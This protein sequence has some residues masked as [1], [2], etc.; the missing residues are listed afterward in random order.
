MLFR[1]LRIPNVAWYH[2]YKISKVKQFLTTEQLKTV[3]HAY[4]ISRLDQNNSLLLGLPKFMIK[5]LQMIQ[6]AAARLLLG[7]R[8]RDHVTPLLIQLHW[9]PVEKRI[10]FKVLLL[11][12]KSLHDI[13]PAYL[14]ELLVPY[15]PSS[16]VSLRSANKELLVL[17]NRHYVE[18]KKRDFAYRGPQEWN[19]LPS[20]IKESK[21]VESFKRALKTYFFRLAYL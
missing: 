5:R 7:G 11:V 12:Y 6:N 15:E 18:T 9:L 4:V 8:K 13:G 19:M 3:I 21:D 17:P 14:K 2:L 1:P 10:I 16:S 20:D